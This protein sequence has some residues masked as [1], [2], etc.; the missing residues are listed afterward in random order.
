MSKSRRRRRPRKN[1]Y[2]PLTGYPITAGI[3]TYIGLGVVGRF[4][5]DTVL[6]AK[7]IAREP[8]QTDESFREAQLAEA[9]RLAPSHVLVWIGQIV[10]GIAAY[11]AAKTP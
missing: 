8:G 4:A 7:T 9:K 11:N 2:G 5:A 6:Q 3:L 1:P 10:G